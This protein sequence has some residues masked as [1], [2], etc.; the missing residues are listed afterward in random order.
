MDRHIFFLFSFF[1]LLCSVVLFQLPNFHCPRNQILCNIDLPN[2]R[3]VTTTKALKHHLSLHCST[4]STIDTNKRLPI[5]IVPGIMSSGLV[6]KKSEVD[7]NSIGSRVWINPVALGIAALYKGRALE[8]VLN[9]KNKRNKLKLKIDEDEEGFSDAEEDEIV[10]T[11]P[12]MKKEQVKEE[13]RCK[14]TWLHHLSLSD[15]MCTERKG[16][17][18]RPIPGLDGVDFLTDLATIKVGAS[19]VFGPLIKILESK[20]YTPSKDLDA[21]TYD[22]RIPPSELEK[23][24][25][26][27]TKSLERI[28]KMYSDSENTPVVL[29]CHS[30]GCKVGH[31]LLGFAKAHR[32]QKV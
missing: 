1:Q 7:D 18:I 19:Y 21:V 6:V 11:P 26:Y 27:F 29:M 20:G 3:I 30:M 8:T 31:Y 23:R 15:D 16:N 5:L 17:E 22:W 4:M 10:Q 32:G 9:D 12:G 25:G 13:L 24:D 14:S 28:E 2:S